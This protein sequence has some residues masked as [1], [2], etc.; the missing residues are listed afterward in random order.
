MSKG[1][2]RDKRDITALR[3]AKRIIS[4]TVTT[5]PKLPNGIVTPRKR[6]ESGCKGAFEVL[7]LDAAFAATC[8]AVTHSCEHHLAPPAGRGWQQRASTGAG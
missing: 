5:V 1:M 2:K 8:E 6:R 3:A 7:A 4:S